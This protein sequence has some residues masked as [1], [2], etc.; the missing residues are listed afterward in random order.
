MGYPDGGGLTAAEAALI[1]IKEGTT[2]RLIC[3]VRDRR[4]GDRRKDR[5]S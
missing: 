1:A 3:R 5:R 2:A 4:R